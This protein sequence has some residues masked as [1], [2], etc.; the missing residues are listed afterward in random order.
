MKCAASLSLSS[1]V[2]AKSARTDDGSP[3]S[4]FADCPDLMIAVVRVCIRSSIEQARVVW[5]W[6]QVSK[7][8]YA[9]VVYVVRETL[10][11]RLR[12]LESALKTWK[13]MPLATPF[14]FPEPRGPL[15]LCYV[16]LNFDGDRRGAR[17]RGSVLGETAWYR[18][19]FVWAVS[20]VLFPDGRVDLAKAISDA[21][22]T[23]N[24]QFEPAYQYF[25]G[26]FDEGFTKEE[27]PYDA[28]WSQAAEYSPQA[29]LSTFSTGLY[30]NSI[31]MADSG[32]RQRFTRALLDQLSGPLDSIAFLVFWSQHVT[33]ETHVY[34]HT[35]LRALQRLVVELVVEW[36]CPGEKYS[37]WWEGIF[38]RAWFGDR[39]DTL[40][41]NPVYLKYAAAET[42]RERE[43]NLRKAI[44]NFENPEHRRR[45][46]EA[47][48]RDFEVDVR[49]V[50]DHFV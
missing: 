37:V 8:A 21:A 3:V 20:R 49:N 41:Y 27:H 31:N 4:G 35:F 23:Y 38:F 30:S 48:V 36:R 32:N 18:P 19:L 47:A 25:T 22:K 45:L 29:L 12:A 2:P 14:P 16:E 28:K 33:F 39:P 9:S 42:R 13:D 17:P 50:R 44:E 1:D 26:R 6:R 34:D 24:P 43:D 10:Q 40:V 46:I 11:P 7:A 15:P 5:S